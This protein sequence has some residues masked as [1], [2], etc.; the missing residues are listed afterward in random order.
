MS[1][2]EEQSPTRTISPSI[3]PEDL[4]RLQEVLAQGPIFMTAG[5]VLDGAQESHGSDSA[6]WGETLTNQ[7]AFGVPVDLLRMGE[8]A[9]A[10]LPDPVTGLV[11]GGSLPIFD[12]DPAPGLDFQVRVTRPTPV[13]NFIRQSDAAALAAAQEFLQG[14][15]ILRQAFLAVPAS[16]PTGPMVPLAEVERLL[17]NTSRLIRGNSSTGNSRSFDFYAESIV[18]TLRESA[19]RPSPDGESSLS[20][21]RALSMGVEGDE[22]AQD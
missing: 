10:R 20:G 11:P 3:S 4:G 1:D 15:G 13:T 21:I 16:A 18:R 17:R 12:R 2:E 19:T 14:P 8:E 7:I 5:M 6:L 22:D 9:P